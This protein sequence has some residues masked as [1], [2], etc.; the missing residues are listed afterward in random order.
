[1]ATEVFLGLDKVACGLVLLDVAAVGPCIDELHE[2]AFLAL[3]AMYGLQIL[4]GEAVIIN[5]L[6]EK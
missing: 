4:S 2:V 6:L 3:G 5:N 1:M